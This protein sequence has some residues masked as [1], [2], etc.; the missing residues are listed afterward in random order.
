MAFN[1]AA[2]MPN[3]DEWQF[4]MHN[5]TM[6]FTVP[7]FGSKPLNDFL[8]NYTDDN[9]YT[10][11]NFINDIA[12]TTTLSAGA[13]NENSTLAINQKVDTSI[14]YCAMDNDAEFSKRYFWT[15]I[16]PAEVKKCDSTQ[17]ALHPVAMFINTAGG[18]IT[19]KS[20]NLNTRS[21]NQND[22]P[23][24][25]RIENIRKRTST[26]NYWDSPQNKET[27]YEVVGN[28][29]DTYG[30]NLAPVT[31][32]EYKKMVFV[33]YVCCSKVNP[34]DYT[35]WNEY[36]AVENKV[37]QVDL[38]AYCNGTYQ[39]K[40]IK[41][42]YPYIY[43][44]SFSPVFG[45][46]TPNLDEPNHPLAERTQ[47][48]Y[49]FAATNNRHGA[50][51]QPL[52]L[53]D[54]N[55]FNYASSV[56]TPV[57]NRAVVY[58]N[59]SKMSGNVSVN[60]CNWNGGDELYTGL[61]YPMNLGCSLGL[62]G[63]NSTYIIVPNMK[64]T[65]T[66]SPD[67]IYPTSA[68]I[69]AGLEKFWYKVLH[70]DN[71]YT[72][73]HI[74]VWLDVKND[75]ES[76]EAFREYCRKQA[77]YLG[78]FFT[79]DYR[80]AT[81]GTLTQS[82]MH[83]GIIDDNGITHGRYVSGEDI[84]KQKQWNWGDPIKDTPYDPNRPTPGDENEEPSDPYVYPENM[85]TGFNSFGTRYAMNQTRLNALRNYFNQLFS[86]AIDSGEQPEVI[87][88]YDEFLA[89]IDKN[90]MGE[91]PISTVKS[92]LA[93]PF[94]LDIYTNTTKNEYVHL[95][96]NELK[97]FM[98]FETPIAEVLGDRITDGDGIIHI[99][100]GS[101]T[102][103]R[104][105]NDFRDFEP[106]SRAELSIP[107]HGTVDLTASVWIGH[108][109]SVEFIVDLATGSSIAIISRDGTPMISVTGNMAIQVPITGADTTAFINQMFSSAIG[110]NTSRTQAISHGISIA[111][112]VLSGVAGVATNNMP[113]VVGSATSLTS[114][115]LN[116]ASDVRN[117]KTA[118]FQADHI[119]LS[120]LTIGS[121][122]PSTSTALDT[123]CRIIRHYP[124][125]IPNWDSAKYAH[126]IGYM[127]NISGT[128]GSFKG[129]TVFSNVNVNGIIC[130]EQEKQ[131]II[132]ACMNGIYL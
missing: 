121:T 127:C 130:T 86:V 110:Y 107:F 53:S 90:F 25:E 116:I 106:Y 65:G 117:M 58:A 43:S 38:H 40:P 31:S 112:N 79:D 97:G 57:T 128:V 50:A 10:G 114:N 15:N 28:R 13:G 132:K 14:A 73:D 47:V 115:A 29:Y 51:F 23:W 48:S 20:I 30:N 33:I 21:T 88:N 35:T 17:D 69:G 22:R 11:T 77:A 123:H 32:F 109:I 95:G 34:N 124:K 87:K 131:M 41:D 126:T 6:N 18:D 108:I 44:I 113:L 74:V 26:T 62:T 78:C 119:S 94:N 16:W 83:L 7:W 96:A 102:Y 120:R 98:W 103:V 64:D 12:N 63:A 111:T 2:Y 59:Q 46:Y 36:H 101:Y 61:S 66:L 8:K 125:M 24:G 122:T 1:E 39:G 99:P 5:N 60:T 89:T 71:N 4:K 49:G 37:L 56:D 129:F 80:T 3:T 93:Y 91:T 45:E 68:Y 19:D 118:E 100:M 104:K 42:E 67:N 81:R 72:Q 55:G 85:P 105:F 84:T 9:Y 75:F 70:T 54:C 52:L 27:T 82:D 76:I 92:I